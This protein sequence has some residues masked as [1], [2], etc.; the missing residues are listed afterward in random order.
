M[1]VDPGFRTER[2]LTFTFDLGGS[3]YDSARAHV[4][5]RDLDR[6]LAAAGRFGCGLLVH[7][8]A[9]RRRLGHGVHRRGLPAGARGEHWRPVNAVSPGYF[10]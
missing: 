6:R 1:G 10:R 4:F 7:A 3:G 8:A 2:L 9:R 5:L